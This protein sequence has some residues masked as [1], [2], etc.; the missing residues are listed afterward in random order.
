GHACSLEV[1]RVVVFAT[2]QLE[3]AGDRLWHKAEVCAARS[4]EFG[5]IAVVSGARWAV[6]F[7]S[8]SKE[9]T[10]PERNSR[11]RSTAPPLFCIPAP[12]LSRS[13]QG[14]TK[15]SSTRRFDALAAMVFPREI[16]TEEPCDSTLKL[17]R[18]TP[19]A[20]M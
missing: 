1:L 15:T 6:H 17:V 13:T 8:D 10:E 12:S 5:V 11:R 19:Y 16:S 20:E 7:S 3:L 14:A 18:E 2:P 4:A 9:R